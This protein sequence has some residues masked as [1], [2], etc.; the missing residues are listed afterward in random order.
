MLQH[1]AHSAIKTKKINT[2][3][4]QQTPH[5]QSAYLASKQTLKQTI[6]SRFVSEEEEEE[7]EEKGEREEEGEGER[8]R[9][10]EGGGGE[11][12]TDRLTDRYREQN[13]LYSYELHNDTHND[14][15]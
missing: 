9:E 5:T 12:Q 1:N 11:R 7:D 2:R 15:S 13:T 14:S 8:E 10:R 3:K 6:Q 4:A